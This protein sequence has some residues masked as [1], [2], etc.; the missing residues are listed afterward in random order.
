MLL[1]GH[2]ASWVR[3]GRDVYLFGSDC[4]VENCR[5]LEVARLIFLLHA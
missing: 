5:F 2:F 1:G 3:R 4:R